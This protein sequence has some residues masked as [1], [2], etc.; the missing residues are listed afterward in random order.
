MT[1]R[2]PNASWSRRSQQRNSKPSFSRPQ[3]QHAVPGRRH[4]RP[5]LR[6]G[7]PAGR[8]CR[9]HTRHNRAGAPRSAAER[10]RL[11]RHPR[12]ADAGN[13][14]AGRHRAG[15]VADIH[16]EPWQGIRLARHCAQ[17]CEAV[18][19]PRQRYP[20]QR[21]HAAGLA[22]RRLAATDLGEVA[23]TQSRTISHTAAHT[24]SS[25]GSRIW[26]A[27]VG[28]WRTRQNGAALGQPALQRRKILQT[29]RRS[30]APHRAGW[31]QHKGERDGSRTRHPQDTCK[32]ACLSA[33]SK[34]THPTSAPTPG[35]ASD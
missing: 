10:V 22:C 19:L 12:A 5:D 27:P 33:S 35:L 24:A 25:S 26:R 8:L 9:N 11:D 6:R 4:D 14:T 1:I 17:Q 18:A 29:E 30:R 34:S 20:R 7:R 2:S 16:R 23:G 3:G 21:A 31:R 28:S 13:V 15:Q 32:T